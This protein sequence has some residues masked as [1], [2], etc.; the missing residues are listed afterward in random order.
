M[1]Q[2]H[3]LHIFFFYKRFTSKFKQIFIIDALQS[4][5]FTKR[6]EK[7]VH[8]LIRPRTVIY[9][10]YPLLLGNQFSKLIELFCNYKD[11]FLCS[12]HNS[13]FVLLG[14]VHIPA[15]LC[16]V[17]VSTCSSILNAD[18]ASCF[19][20]INVYL[21]IVCLYDPIELNKHNFIIASI[22]IANI[23]FFYFL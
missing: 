13:Y 15:V 10:Q 18:V 7:S 4:P 22:I 6:D 1:R 23:I 20:H 19:F 21:H 2:T 14:S 17:L 8:T 5:N 3:F 9:P 12:S 16:H 11:T